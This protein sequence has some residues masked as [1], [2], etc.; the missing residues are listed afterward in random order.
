MRSIVSIPD[1]PTPVELISLKEV[2]RRTSRS[3]STIYRWMDQ[4]IF[5]RQARKE[6]GTTSALW[7]A[8]EV[9]GFN[10]K[11]RNPPCEL[12]APPPSLTP[13]RWNTNVRQNAFKIRSTSQSNKPL[14]SKKRRATAN[15]SDACFIVGPLLI[16]TEEAY[17]EPRT[18]RIFSVIGH[19]PIVQPNMAA[20]SAQ[21]RWQIGGAGGDE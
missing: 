12:S 8:D 15:D 16:G 3:R 13:H 1:S 9:D 7:F 4:G 19:V 10:T 2:M 6:A 18:G 14:M 11:L 17:F 20:Q 21:K 5:P